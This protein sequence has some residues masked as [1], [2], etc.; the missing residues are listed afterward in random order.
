MADFLRRLFGGTKAE[1]TFDGVDLSAN[2]VI[3]VSGLP[4]SGTSMM[5]KVLEAGG[6]PVLVDG[7]RT[8]DVDNPKGYYEFERVKQLDKGDVQWVADAQGKVVKVISALLVHLPSEYNYKIIFM[9]R[10]FDEVLR[11]QQKMLANRGEEKKGPSD[12]EMTKLFVKHLQSIDEWFKKQ[13]NMDVL[14]VDYNRMVLEPQPYIEKINQFV[15]KP[16]DVDAMNAVVDPNL[17]RNRA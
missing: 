9:L 4:R 12:E 5:M 13:P 15:P 14:H 16:L 10:D 8:A 11:S 1:T 6:I 17:Y 3:I 2:D 7:E